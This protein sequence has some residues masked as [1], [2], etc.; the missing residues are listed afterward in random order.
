VHATEQPP[1]LE[2]WQSA[3]A[4]QS[5]TYWHWRSQRSRRSEYWQIDVSSQM[6]LLAVALQFERHCPEMTSHSQRPEASWLQ[7]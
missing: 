7:S 4:E 3:R 5:S 2:A 6:A 1:V